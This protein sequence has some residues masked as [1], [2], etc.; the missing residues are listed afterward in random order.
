MLTGKPDGAVRQIRQN[1]HIVTDYKTGSVLR[2]GKGPRLPKI[3]AHRYRQQ[4]LFYKLLIE[5]SRDYHDYT[6]SQ[7]VLQ[8]VEPDDWGKLL[9]CD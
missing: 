3:K 7:G 9:I 4:L 1:R 8:F 6:M 5:N 2:Q